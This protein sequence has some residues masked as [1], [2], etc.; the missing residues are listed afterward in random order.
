MSLGIRRVMPT[1]RPSKRNR[2]VGL[3]H[4]LVHMHLRTRVNTTVRF[5][6]LN[7]HMHRVV[8]RKGV[9]SILPALSVIGTTREFFMRAPIVVSSVVRVG[10][11]D[12]PK[13]K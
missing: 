11:Q 1:G 4:L 8:W 6:E 12:C 13:R 2:K 5:L 3:P 7:L 9:V 10:M